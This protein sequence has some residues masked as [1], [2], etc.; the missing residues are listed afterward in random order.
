MELSAEAALA[1][2][3]VAAP[4]LRAKR[5]FLALS[6]RQG[7]IFLTMTVLLGLGI[8]LR[9]YPSAGYQNLGTDE[10][11]YMVFVKQI[12]SAGISNYDAVVRV[13]VERQYQLREAVVPA[14]RVAFLVPA[15]LCADLFHLRAFTAI[16]AVAAT[17]GV[18]LLLLCALFAYRLGG[19]WPMIGMTALIATAPLEIYLCQRAMIDGYFAFWAV[20]ALWLAW[21]NLQRPRHMGWLISY[22]LCLTILV[23]TKETAAFVVFAILGTL[24]LNRFLRL[25]TVTPQ[26]LAATVAGPALAVL[27][28]VVL[29]GGVGDWIHFYQMFV[30]K[31][32]TNFY[33]VAAQDGPW[34]RYAIDFA[35][36]TPAIVAL[37]IGGIFQLQKG[38]RAGWFMATFVLLALTGLSCVKYGISLRYAAFC[39][40]P[41]TWLACTQ[42]LTLSQRFSTAR[43][44]IVAAG[45]FL[46]LGAIGLNQ[47]ARI[48]V[49][50]GLYD[51][52][53]S[54]LVIKLDMSKSSTAVREQLALPDHP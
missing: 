1:A 14:T 7:L 13:Y 5:R 43:P 24:L 35:L 16:H 17:S 44:A 19:T 10:H 29:V 2:L 23:L 21:E 37:A 9:L 41:L 20:A 22:T 51:P 31:S 48:F 40:I 54:Q 34:Y 36:V 52:I 38:N 26:L 8:F 50:G 47:Y 18:L 53:T 46:V 27:I 15:A 12:Q 42:V 11:G 3:P 6:R 30:A 39:D 32:G 28:L 33:S 49:R 25:G 4:P 45:M